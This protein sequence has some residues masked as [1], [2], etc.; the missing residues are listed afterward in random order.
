MVGLPIVDAML[1]MSFR[2]LR[3]HSPVLPDKT[4]LHHRL[5]ALNLGHATVVRIIHVAMI[6]CGLL[7]VLMIGQVEWL[8]FYV[9]VAYATLLFGSVYVLRK[10]G[11]RVRG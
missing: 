5:M 10:A 11:T 2:V 7:A 8:Q 3:G 6:S 1:V 4:H 9:G